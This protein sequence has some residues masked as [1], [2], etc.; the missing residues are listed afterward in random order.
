MIVCLQRV[1]R[2]EVSVQGKKIGQISK[3]FLLLLGIEKTDTEVQVQRLTEKIVFFR[4][5]EDAVG[6]MNL[7]IQDVKGSVLIVSQFTLVGSTEKGRRP[8]FENAA[9]PEQA[10]IL[11]EVFI[12]EFKQRAIPT[13]SGVFGAM[14]EV[15]LVNDGPVTFVLEEKA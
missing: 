2:A 5:F 8:S 15:E 13:E 7:S 1:S 11:Y 10:K 12:N 4:V 9:L 3:G 6:K 14:M